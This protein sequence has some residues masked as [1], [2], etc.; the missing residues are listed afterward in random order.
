MKLVKE[1]LDEG[2]CKIPSKS[3]AFDIRKK[4]KEGEAY[5]GDI[6]YDTNGPIEDED[7]NESVNEGFAT[8][9]SNKLDSIADLLDYDG[10]AEMLGDNPGLYEVCIEWIDRVFGD[11]L[12]QSGVESERLEFLG[13]YDAAMEAKRNLGDAG[14]DEDE[15]Y[16]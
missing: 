15:G 13:L 12:V 7:T 2:K 9:E 5:K 14:S 4:E 3:Q 11:K 6:K 1:R 10:L 8:D 16:M